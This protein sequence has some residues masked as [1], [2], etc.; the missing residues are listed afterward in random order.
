MDV[1]FIG[2]TLALFGATFALMRLCERV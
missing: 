2:L 1:I